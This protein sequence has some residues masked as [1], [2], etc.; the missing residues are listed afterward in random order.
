M[1][2]FHRLP[3]AAGDRNR[4]S[5]SASVQREP[6]VARRVHEVLANVG[7]TQFPAVVAAHAASV[8]GQVFSQVADGGNGL[9][10]TAGSGES[11][12]TFDDLSVDWPQQG[13]WT[14]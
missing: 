8:A 5:P 1:A 7:L 13:C 4:Y 6:T 9:L 3:R 2:C 10:V 11:V 14:P 12:A